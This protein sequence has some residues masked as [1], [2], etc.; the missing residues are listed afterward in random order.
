MAAATLA[1]WAA[2][3]GGVAK[4]PACASFASQADAQERFFG[5]GGSPSRNAD[6]LDGDGNGVACEDLPGPYAGFATVGYHRQRTFFYGTAS[7]PRGADG[8]GFA[9]LLGN[10]QFADGARR[11]TIY[12]ELPGPDR[13]ISRPL[14][15]EPRPGSGRLLWKLD[16]DLDIAARYYVAFEAQI[17]LSPY[18]PSNCPEFRSR[19]VYLPRPRA[20]RPPRSGP[21]HRPR[22]RAPGPR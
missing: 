8:D 4:A 10:R 21:P 2:A 17:H 3:A 16:R 13:A 15:A 18:K 20:T 5:L 9:C 19:A 11:L 22:L 7:M 14:K 12:R 6:G 1:I